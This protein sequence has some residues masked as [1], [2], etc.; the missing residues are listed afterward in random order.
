MVTS[1]NE[2][3]KAINKSFLLD[4]FWIYQKERFPFFQNGLLIF[5][6]TFSAISYSRICR[7]ASGFIDLGQ[8]I[9]GAI[10]AFLFFFLMRVF[11]EFK[12]AQD[13]AKYRSY[14][15][16]PRG[17]ISLRELWWIGFGV[18]LI[19]I[20]TNFLI[21]PVMLG[22]YFLVLIYLLLMTKEFFVRQWLKAHPVAYMLSHLIIMLLI[23]FYTAGLDWINAGEDTPPK[24]LVFFLITT[25]LNGI[26]IEIGR[27]IR[28]REAE[29]VG[30]ETYSALY[31]S[32]KSTLTWILILFSTF[33]FAV[34][35][36]YVA[37]FGNIALIILVSLLVS[38]LFVSFRFIK[39]QQQS[40]AKQIEQ[41]AWIWTLGMYL[42]L[43]AVPMLI[44]Y[45]KG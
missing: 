32:K 21:M 25:F 35:A 13:D 2:M 44:N 16:V 26:V 10:T 9:I 1:S 24:G 17:L 43:G 45:F 6:F 38:G 37:G 31:G 19:Q 14:R 41:M 12:D 5:A 40:H 42:T 28:S 29:E 8:F 20:I 27:K 15:P 18:I 3:R 22:V 33:I 7:K 11:D 34:I 36:S 39:T 30:V 23:N 4:R